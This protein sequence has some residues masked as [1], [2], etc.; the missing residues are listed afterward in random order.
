M[1]FSISGATHKILS[2]A[3]MS[4][5]L[6]FLILSACGGGGGGG[7]SAPS[8]ASISATANITA[9][10]LTVGTAMASFS[11]LTPS[12][13]ATPYTYSITSGTL[14]AGLSLNVSTG[15]VTG[16]P[17]ATYATANVVF[18][19]KDANN[20]VAS[21]TSNVNFTVA[22][23]TVLYSFAGGIGD[24]SRPDC[25]LIQASDGNFYGVTNIG[26]ANNLGT[27]FK[28]TTS[29]IETVL[30]NFAG[31]IGDGSQPYCSLI[32]ASDGNFYGVTNI[33]GAN[34]LG[35]VFKITTS[36]TETVLYSFAG[37][38]GD[39]ANPE[40]HLIQASDGNLYGLTQTGGAHGWGALFKITTSG[41]ETVLWSFGGTGDGTAPVGS[42]VQAS[43]GNLY[44]LTET[45]GANSVGTV[46]KITTSGTETVLH[47]FSGT[48][49][50]GG[51]PSPS[52]SLIQASDGN[53]YGMTQSWGANGGGMVFR[54]TLSGTES[55]RWSFG[56]TGDGASPQG[57]LI[58]A[59]DGS[60]YGMTLVGGANNLG[61]VFKITTSGIETVLHSFAGGIGDGASPQSGL[62]QASDG[63]FYG[64][65][66]VGGT[67]NL[68]TVF[69]IN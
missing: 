5:P 43:D 3:V 22:A 61:T 10:N 38:I 23:W 31:G 13:G 67:N 39:G 57:G 2:L 41:T 36:G 42:L 20:V 19:V 59:S 55:V 32:Q 29:G 62:I 60:F 27:V 30:H 17:T 37:G 63:S 44:G 16:T 53:L 69:K 4:V 65:T 52:S 48:T 68:G 51:Y 15:A 47:S 24:G 9:Q 40:G 50:D 25:S 6:T 1:K 54:I 18:S 56:G 7:G 26:G 64:M 11:P 28:I 45:G 12:G 8:P 34:N 21:T 49:A 33:G 46:F 14:P 35:T 58:Q 66:L